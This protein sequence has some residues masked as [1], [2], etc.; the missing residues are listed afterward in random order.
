M[1][2]FPS[3]ETIKRLREQ[4]PRGCRIELVQ[5]EDPYAKLNPGDQG[6]VDFVDDAGTLHMIWNCGSTLGLIVGVDQFRK[7]VE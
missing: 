1:S 6:T 5:M 7:V 4:Y 2:K 3:K